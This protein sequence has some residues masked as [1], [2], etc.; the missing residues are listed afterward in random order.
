MA[1]K[2]FRGASLILI[3]AFLFLALTTFVFWMSPIGIGFS[4]GAEKLR[5]P[6]FFNWFQVV[7]W[8]GPIALI[9]G[10]FALLTTDFSNQLEMKVIGIVFAAIF[11]LMF[12]QI[13][14]LIYISG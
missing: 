5:N 12:I 1:Q 2:P 11:L 9:A 3:P 10:P 13:G 7:F 4:D 6:V 8:L 14:T